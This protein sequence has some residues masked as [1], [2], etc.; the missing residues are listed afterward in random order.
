ME[1]SINMNQMGK[2]KVTS[3]NVKY[4]EAIHNSNGKFFTL[5]SRQY[6]ELLCEFGIFYTIKN[7]CLLKEYQK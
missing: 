5:D 3:D 1:L 4:F 6:V 2:W 7:C